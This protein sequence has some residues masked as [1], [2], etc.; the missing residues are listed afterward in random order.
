MRIACIKWAKQCKGN[1][2]AE[3]GILR[4]NQFFP[5]SIFIKRFYLHKYHSYVLSESL[6]N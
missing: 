5:M 3:A 6:F 4:R 1:F 2:I